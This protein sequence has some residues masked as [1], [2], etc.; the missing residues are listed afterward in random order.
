[1]QA[2][3]TLKFIEPFQPSEESAID[4]NE[5][6]IIDAGFTALCFDLLG[7][8]PNNIQVAERLEESGF[9]TVFESSFIVSH[10]DGSYLHALVFGHNN[11]GGFIDLGIA[12]EEHDATNKPTGGYL[13]SYDASGLIRTRVKQEDDIDDYGEDV[14]V[15]HF[16]LLNLYEDAD[17]LAS[18]EATGDEYERQYAKE[19]REKLENDVSF[20]VWGS[21]LGYDG[22]CPPLQEIKQL[23]KILEQAVPRRI[24]P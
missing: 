18:I 7:K 10:S 16:S 15:L 17:E 9:I 24:N 8:Y 5:K 6:E 14:D 2:G 4:K 19:T 11:K 20:E 22:Q 21:E 1:M 13:Y 3:E 12:I 23:I